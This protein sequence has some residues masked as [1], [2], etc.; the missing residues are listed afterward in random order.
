[1]YFFKQQ[2]I[3]LFLSMHEKG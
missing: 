1:L 2:A 3:L